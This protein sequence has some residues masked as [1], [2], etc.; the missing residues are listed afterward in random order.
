[1]AQLG[2]QREGLALAGDGLA[3]G[4]AV[5]AQRVLAAG[6]R[7]ARDERVVAGVEE[8]EAHVAHH[9][10]QGFKLA[11]ERRD[12]AARTHVDGHR[13]ALVAGPAQVGDE[14]GQEGRRQVVDH[15]MPAILHDIERNA[16]AGAGQAADD[17]ELHDD[18]VSGED[19]RSEG[20]SLSGVCDKNARN[21]A[22]E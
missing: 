18:A 15:V 9:A 16:L 22:T 11:R 19:D 14:L 3:E 17:D 8:Q 12:A 2:H 13:D 7:E 20:A 10:A 1:M 6:F 21:A 4:Q 5:V